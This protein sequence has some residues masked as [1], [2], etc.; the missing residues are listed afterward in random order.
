ML[1]AAILQGKVA[2]PSAVCAE[3]PP[4]LDAIILKCLRRNPNQRYVSA[5][6]LA[7]ALAGFQSQTNAA[8]PAISPRPPQPPSPSLQVHNTTL[9]P[10]LE[11]TPQPQPA[12]SP[13][14][15]SATPPAVGIPEPAP[16]KT[17]DSR[18]IHVEAKRPKRSPKA[19]PTASPNVVNSVDGNESAQDAAPQSEL[20]WWFNRL[21]VYL[22][23]INLSAILG[24]VIWS[25]ISDSVPTVANR[26][27]KHYRTL[28]PLVVSEIPKDVVNAWQKHTDYLQLYYLDLHDNGYFRLL[29]QY[30]RAPDVPYLPIF[31]LHAHVDSR[32]P[33][34]GVPYGLLMR[35]GRDLDV[36][37][38]SR[39]PHIT[40]NLYFFAANY[41]VGD[42]CTITDTAIADLIKATQLRFLFLRNC[43]IADQG[44]KT[45]TALPNLQKLDLSGTNITDVGAVHLQQFVHL[46][47]L[48]L[49]NTKLG[50][51]GLASIGRLPKLRVLDLNGTKVTDAGLKHLHNLSELRH[52][53]I[54][55]TEC[56]DKGIIELIRALPKCKVHNN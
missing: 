35:F 29:V 17:H 38:F 4:K 31:K 14:S 19:A 6:A 51:A 27:I 47:G 3:V 15:A 13:P 26:S 22:L 28:P 11:M 1:V 49:T 18:R 23:L 37:D 50:D 16:V 56:T 44:L 40:K 21:V 52:L 8:V 25:Y 5:E 39:Y 54:G 10:V 45:L 32:V 42:N 46:E 2:R 30:D 53:H 55:R 7:T 36:I 43:K 41:F 9:T 34:P 20:L 48:H 33:D 24:Y 12:A